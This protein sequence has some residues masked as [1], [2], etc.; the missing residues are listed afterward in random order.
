MTNCGNDAPCEECAADYWCE[1]VK[2]IR[3]FNIEEV[4][5]EI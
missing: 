3:K 5:N 1:D 4:N 2:E